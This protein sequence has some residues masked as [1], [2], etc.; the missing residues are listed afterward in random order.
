MPGQRIPDLTAIAGASTANDDNLVIF[1]TSLNTTK[2]ILRSQLAAGLVGDLPY[3][4]TG[5]GAVDTTVQAKLQESVSVQDF[6]ASTGTTAAVNA[7][8]FAAAWTASNPQA[9]LVKAGTYLFTGTVVGQFYSFG[10]V[11]ITG[12]TVTSITNVVA[13]AILLE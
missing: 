12:G 5:T 7:A 4:A 6:G 11:T 3:K 8:A 9:V 10:Q 1:D 13:G 2:R